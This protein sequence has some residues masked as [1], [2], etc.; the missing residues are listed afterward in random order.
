MGIGVG[1]PKLDLKPMLV[2]KDEAVDGNV[3][4]VDF[5]LKKNKIDVLRHRPHRCPPARSR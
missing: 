3:K 1:K 5:L 4:G 2:F